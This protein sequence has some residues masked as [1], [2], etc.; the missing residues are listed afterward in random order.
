MNGAL[1]VVLA[2]IGTVVGVAS[3]IY[4][5]RRSQREQAQAEERMHAEALGREF[6]KG[7]ASRDNEIAL[8]K[9]ELAD[10]RQDLADKKLELRDAQ[11][12]IRRL[13]DG[14]A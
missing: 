6:S 5:V 10:A 7:A 4:T 8:L 11:L 13:R 14:R 1:G 9:S 12:E 2:L 3:L